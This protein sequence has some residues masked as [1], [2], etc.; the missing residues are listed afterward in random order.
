M[1]L[2]QGD[3]F[4]VV[5]EASNGRQAVELAESANP[6]VVIMDIAMP[7]LNGIQAASQIARKH[8]DVGVIILSMY[9]DE[10]YLMRALAA[11]AKG[12]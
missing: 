5:G 4:E 10:S 3:Q 12:Y 2:Q 11:G 8:P 1:Q 9:S 6:D 7:N